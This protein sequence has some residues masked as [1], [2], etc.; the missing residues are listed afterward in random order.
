MQGILLAAGRGSRF[1]ADKLRHP[2]P[3][4]TPMA[5]AAARNLHT[6]LPDA[7]AVVNGEDAELIALLEQAGLSVSVCPHAADGMGASLAW[8]VAQSETADGWLIALADMPWIA[9]ATIQT[10]AGA[11]TGPHSIAAPTHQGRRGHPVAFGRAYRDE[12]MALGGDEG[13]RR[14]LAAHAAE[15]VLLPCADPGILLDIDSPAQL[16]R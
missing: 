9:L 16:G 11:V 4:G 8:G 6:A 15:V 5:L 3:D 14:L 1:G 13:A 7:L 12:L 2:L 10:V